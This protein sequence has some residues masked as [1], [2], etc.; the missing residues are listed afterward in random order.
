MGQFRKN[1]YGQLSRQLLIHSDTMG[2]LILM[3]V[4]KIALH[5]ALWNMELIKL[6][7]TALPYFFARI[8][9]DYIDNIRRYCV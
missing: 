5:S 3:Y 2:R 1:P 4:Y 6:V 9:K 8:F 7:I